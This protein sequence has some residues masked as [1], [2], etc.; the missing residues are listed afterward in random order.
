MVHWLCSTIVEVVR[1]LL[2][3]SN[4]DFSD[5]ISLLGAVNR[6]MALLKHLFE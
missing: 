6:D 2:S 5:L 1:L 3:M 4:L